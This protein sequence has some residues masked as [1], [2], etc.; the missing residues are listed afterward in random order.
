MD[1]LI[2]GRQ[3]RAT[4]AF[5]WLVPSEQHQ[6]GSEERSGSSPDRRSENASRALPSRLQ[7][8]ARVPDRRG[9]LRSLLGAIATAGAP[10]EDPTRPGLCNGSGC[11]VSFPAFPPAHHRTSR[12]L[13][14]PK[15]PHGPAA[16]V[17]PLPP[18]GRSA[19]CTLA[20]LSPLPP[21][22]AEPDPQDIP[23]TRPPAQEDAGSAK[24]ISRPALS[25]H[26]KAN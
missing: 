7:R 20:E 21:G 1:T 5:R 18:S 22:R 13:L 26:G 4:T 25:S 11:S 15:P 12:L 16:A 9:A 19:T 17:P 2:T 23:S 3:T 8:N 6:R 24:G 10:S 14:L